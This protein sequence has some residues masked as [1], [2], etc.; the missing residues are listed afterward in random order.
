MTDYDLVE[1][2][3][4]EFIDRIKSL[5]ASARSED[6]FEFQRLRQRAFTPSEAPSLDNILTRNQ[7]R[8]EIKEILDDMNEN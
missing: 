5:R 8:E 2:Y 7:I 4:D 6:L 3:L 1:D